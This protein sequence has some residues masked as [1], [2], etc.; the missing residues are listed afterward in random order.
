MHLSQ[1]LW[2]RLPRLA[3]SSGPDGREGAGDA[4]AAPVL[5]GTKRGGQPAITRELRQPSTN[6]AIRCGASRDMRD[7]A[8]VAQSHRK[9]ARRKH[10]QEWQPVP[11][12]RFQH[13][14]GAPTGR[15]RVG[16]P[17]HVTGK[18]TKCLER[19]DSAVCRPTA[20]RLLRS[21]L[22]ACGMGLH[23]GQ[24]LGRGFGLLALVGQR[25]RRS[26]YR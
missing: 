24:R 25:C 11:A 3:P 4:G 19:V 15:Q 18:G 8:G 2:P 20:P 5:G 7:V 12:R 14:R 17:L 13:A 22:E 10:L 1:G 9:A 16:E 26:G 6:K 21:H 23:E